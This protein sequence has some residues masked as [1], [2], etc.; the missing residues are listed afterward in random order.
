MAALQKHAGGPVGGTAAPSEVLNPTCAEES[1]ARRWEP[2]LLRASAHHGLSRWR[3]EAIRAQ[4]AAN[5]NAKARLPISKRCWDASKGHCRFDTRR[6]R[7]QSCTDL[8]R[9]SPETPEP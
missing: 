8:S 1:G 3:A 2:T 6:E 5:G 4:S 9:T 7:T